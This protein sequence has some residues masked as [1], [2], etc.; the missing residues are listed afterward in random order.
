M[1]TFVSF[2]ITKVKVLSRE[3]TGSTVVVEYQGFHQSIH[4]PT[5]VWIDVCDIPLHVAV[6]DVKSLGAR[7]YY[8]YYN[9]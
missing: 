3:K 9:H 2:K 7:H 1:R 6:K 5:T 4:V 8:N